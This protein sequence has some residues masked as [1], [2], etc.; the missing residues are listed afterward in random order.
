MKSATAPGLSQ[1]FAPAHRRV[2]I[3]AGGTALA[4]LGSAC[5]PSRGTDQFSFSAEEQARIEELTRDLH[6]ELV[7]ERR[8][9]RKMDSVY[10]ME[11]GAQA[12]RRLAKNARY[13]RWSPDGQHIA[14]IRD[15]SI[16]IMDRDGGHPHELASFQ[17]C[18]SVNFDPN[19]KFLIFPDTDGLKTVPV[20]G[21]PAKMLIPGNEFVAA[22]PTR[23]C[24]R[25]IAV[26]SRRRGEHHLVAYDPQ[27]G[28][29]KYV[30]D[31]C[32]DDI[33]PDG[34]RFTD[35][36]GRHLSMLI[37][38]WDDDFKV[39]GRLD[40]P[41]G[42]TIDNEFWSNDPDSIVTRTEQPGHQNIYLIS[43]SRNQSYKLTGFND[44]DRPDLRVTWKREPSGQESSAK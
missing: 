19:G 43:V 24:A 44:C 26:E 31:G 4:L 41:G 1:R 12:A 8:D 23:D 10:V 28:T 6:G 9:E 7:F 30:D 39:I 16:M 33:A 37:R 11:V 32:S 22:A 25:I 5:G 35:L 34:Q 15:H 21:G 29:S 13:P 36:A 42:Y 14:F 38:S 18:R 27:R 2:W 20:E 17:K 3:I 40:A